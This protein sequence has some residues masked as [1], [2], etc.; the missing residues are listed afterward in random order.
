MK[1]WQRVLLRRWS[2]VAKGTVGI[3]LLA[4]LALGASGRVADWLHDPRL[5][6]SLVFVGVLV[7]F[8]GLKLY[9]ERRSTG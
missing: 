5:A 7:P 3:G 9:L 1:P 8:V 4:A 6:F 2:R